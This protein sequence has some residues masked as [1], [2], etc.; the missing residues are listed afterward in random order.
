MMITV[1]RVADFLT[2]TVN[3]KAYSVPYNDEKFMRMQELVRTA[4]MVDTLEDLKDVISTFLPL[5]QDSYKETIEHMTPYLHVNQSTGEYFLHKN[6]ALSKH[7]LPGAFVQRIVK[8]VETRND[9]TPIVKTIARFM[10]NPNYSA[11][12]CIRLANY[13]NLTYVDPELEA[14]M[15]TNGV[16]QGMAKAR[17]TIFQTTMTQEGLLNTYKV[18]REINHKYV[19]DPEAE[20]GVKLTDR[21]D[22]D[23]DEFS[24]LKT[25]IKPE[26]IEDRVFEPVMMGQGGDAFFCGDV[27]GHIIRV[28]Q[29]HMLDSWDKVDCNDRYSGVKG[30]H[31]G[32]LD[33]IRGFQT[34]RTVTHNIFVD[35]MDIGAFTDDG[36]GAIRVRRYFVHSS[37]AGVN[38][39]YYNSSSYAALNDAEYAKMVQE[40]V[41]AENKAASKAADAAAKAIEQINLLNSF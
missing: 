5:T 39:G 10:R 40:A 23:V 7:P 25:Y 37:F 4:G 14:S 16:D 41:E 13:L 35:P 31:C 3:G 18:S 20:D 12:K 1:N 9:V 26:F 33:Y 21:H 19:K 8:A 24:G 22:F 32:N 6:G 34:D 15:V 36:T 27:E 38:R 11:A 30:L 28:G 17:A 29:V 2:G